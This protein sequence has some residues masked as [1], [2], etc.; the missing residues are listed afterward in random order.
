MRLVACSLVLA[1][2][3]LGASQET[4]RFEPSFYVQ[5]QYRD[6]DEP[7]REQ[8]GLQFRRLRFGG[9][10]SFDS[11]TSARVIFDGV[12]GANNDEV[13]LKDA[14]IL[15]RFQANGEPTGWSL[16]AGQFPLPLGYELSRSSATREMPEF[17]AYNRA[18]FPGEQIRGVM[19]TYGGLRFGVFNSLA[20]EDTEARGVERQNMAFFG[21]YTS[22]GEDWTAGV[23]AFVGERPSF[24][25][26]SATSPAADRQ[27]VSLHGSWRP[28]ERF[29]LRGEVLT[30][31]DR[32]SSAAGNAGLFDRPLLGWHTL[33]VF[34]L[35]KP[36]LLFA[37]VGGFD[38]DTASNGNALKEFGFGYRAN[39]ADGLTATLAF[40]RIDDPARPR[41]YSITT[42]RFQY[43]F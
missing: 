23:G 19:A 36:G 20:S 27:L 24:V 14:F 38:R 18:L 8:R 17:S 10:Y 15:H 41:M 13:R 31:R 26:T 43:Q 1:F 9:T 22:Q 39:L 16:Q 21:G 6:S 33:G 5:Y 2:V 3:A 35:G 40:E 34:D 29:T 42:V 32:V 30:G 12:S 7:G 25:G 4:R 11:A 28:V 37:R